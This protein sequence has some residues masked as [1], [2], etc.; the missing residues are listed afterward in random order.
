MYTRMLIPLDGSKT[1]EKVLPYARFLAAR[2]KLPL[3]LLVVIDL[4]EI[5]ARMSPERA[6]FFHTMAEKAVRSSEQYLKRV[7]ATFPGAD[8]KCTVEK[9]RPA[10]IIIEKA[11]AD[12][13][14]LISMATHGHSGINRWLLGS[15]AEKVLRG[16]TNPLLLVKAK[17]EAKTEGEAT[18][19]SVVVP[20]DGSELAET[21]LPTVAE[22]AKRLN[23]EVVLFRAYTIPYTAYVPLEGFAPP[24]DQELIQAFRDEVTAY[25]EKRTEAMRQMGVDKVSYTAKE[26]FAADEIISLARKTPDNLIAMCTHG[27]S[28]VKRWVLGSVTETVVRHS[29]DPVLVIRAT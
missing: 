1:A 25:L 12:K 2:L 27:R 11:A 6:Q 22:L 10:D 20:L 29:G 23:L 19:R 15:V 26:G 24:V 4:V 9:G 21:V 13:E 7:A 3:E 5:A 18:L 14:T 8:V 28:G 17:E 16:A